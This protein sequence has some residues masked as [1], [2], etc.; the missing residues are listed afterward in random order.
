MMITRTWLFDLRGRKSEHL[1]FTFVISIFGHPFLG[2]ASLGGGV[3]WSWKAVEFGR[4]SIPWQYQIRDS[5][6]T[7]DLHVDNIEHWKKENLYIVDLEELKAL[8]KIECRQFKEF[9]PK[10]ES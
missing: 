6:T 4:G 2:S 10:H 8:N 3:Y 7:R 1:H 9:D 5:T